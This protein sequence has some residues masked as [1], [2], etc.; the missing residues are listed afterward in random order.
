MSAGKIVP[1]VLDAVNHIKHI[2]DY[3]A[4]SAQDITVPHL[5]TSTSEKFKSN[6]QL[7]SQAGYFFVRIVLLASLFANTSFE[8][9][10]Q[11]SDM[12][13][14]V[15]THDVELKTPLKGADVVLQIENK[16]PV[17]GNTGANGCADITFEA[18]A[19][20][21]SEAVTE[22]PSMFGVE[23]PYPNPVVNE[24][25]IPLS[26]PQPQPVSFEIFDVTG[27][28]IFPLQRAN[29]GAGKHLIS[30]EAGSLKPGLYV[31]RVEAGQEV[32]TGQ[33]I[34]ISGGLGNALR[35]RIGEESDAPTGVAPVP[36]ASEAS[37]AIRIDAKHSGYTA[38][39]S[40]VELVDGETVVLGLERQ[41]PGLFSIQSA[42]TSLSPGYDCETREVA[43]VA[44]YTIDLS[45]HS[46]AYSANSLSPHFL[47]TKGSVFSNSNWTATPASYLKGDDYSY[48]STRSRYCSRDVEVDTWSRRGIVF[49]RLTSSGEAI[50]FP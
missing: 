39:A 31:Y 17:K 16:Q 5:C 20:I 15:C 47:N 34:K 11:R 8:V 46:G 45:V 40:E 26:L 28:A 4:P 1:L 2:M 19:A 44:E 22:I 3:Q 29:L 14:T 36:D 38:L 35:V 49:L 33:F 42:S 6:K 13:V 23:A 21:L 7:S 18:P 43:P 50:Y 48:L 27:R 9:F 30:L 25:S 10:A 12:V 32:E 37:I 41:A 24:V